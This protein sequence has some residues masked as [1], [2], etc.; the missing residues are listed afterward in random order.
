MLE[1]SPARPGVLPQAAAEPQAPP[2]EPVVLPPRP[3]TWL[4]RVGK[5]ALI[6][7]LAGALLGAIEGAVIGAIL[8]PRRDPA[9][10][11]LV[12]AFDRAVF[13]GLVGTAFGAAVGSLDW[14]LRW[15][16]KRRA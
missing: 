12:I 13:L 3:P 15:G 1:F 7:G 9:G 2:L 16:R 8:A 10:L 14:Y 5:C 11:I 6:L 4:A